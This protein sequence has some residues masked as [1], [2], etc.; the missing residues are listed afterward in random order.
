[1]TRKVV[2]TSAIAILV[3]LI[4]SGF[5][6]LTSTASATTSS[7]FVYAGLGE[8]EYL[9]P[10]VDWESNGMNVIQNVYETLFWY[11]GPN[12]DSFVPLLATDLP[13]VENGQISADGLSYTVHV[14]SN[15]KFH[16]GTTLTPDDVVYSFQRVL[17]IHDVAGASWMLEQVLTDYISYYIGMT[18]SDYL[19]DS[20]QAPW[21]VAILEPLGVDHIITEEDVQAVAEAAVVKIDLSTVVFR[22]THGYAGFISILA[23]PVSS[24]ISKEFVEAHGGVVNGYQNDYMNSHMCG[25]GPF[26]LVSWNIGD[27]V[28]LTRNDAY[29]GSAPALKD[30]YIVTANDVSTRLLMLQTGDADAVDLPQSYEPEIAGNTGITVVKGIPKF[31]LA[32]AAFNFNINSAAA[33]SM[34]GTSITDNFFHDIHMRRAFAHLVDYAAVMDMLDGNAMQPNGPIPKGMFGYDESVPRDTFDLV[35]AQ[36]ELEMAINPVT[37]NSWWTDGFSIPLFYNMGNVYRQTILEHL[38]M[39]I[40]SLGARFQA[41]LIGLDWPT[42]LSE[43]YNT[44][45]Y[46]SLSIVGF[47]VDYADPDDFATFLLDSVYG[48]YP[49]FRGYSNPMVDEKVRAAMG[50]LDSTARAQMYSELSYMLRDDPP[51]IWLYQTMCFQA[52]RSW[53]MGY[54]FNPMHNGL[55]YASLSKSTPAGIEIVKM[56]AKGGVETWTFEPEADGMWYAEISNNG[57]TKL[58]ISITDLTTGQKI[59]K[60]QISFA[61]SGPTGTVTTAQVAMESGHV[62]QITATPYGRVGA[63]ATLTQY[64]AG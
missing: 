42:Y 20:Y 45:S 22:L 40:E 25:T 5:V 26:K 4:A 62:Y 36:S 16:D 1:V 47:S 23:A 32:F 43:F 58:T 39:T 64:F 28:H 61:T 37:G 10:A 46:F 60:E 34:Y 56:K 15:M 8:P 48:G 33:N 12:A 51:Y 52:M 59:S 6:G 7:T 53:V 41:V 24:I 13:T 38:K 11:D 30:V 57:L 29:W 19:A 35:A 2:K 49:R 14:R 44:Y 63:S 54:Y 18:V 55:Y 21:I 27:R 9:D 17:R 50:E 3:A 31:E